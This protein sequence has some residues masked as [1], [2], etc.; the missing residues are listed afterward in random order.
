MVGEEW[1]DEMGIKQST[2]RGVSGKSEVE[3]FATLNLA[4]IEEMSKYTNFL[5]Q[6]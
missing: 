5:Y 2:F 4:K 1:A 3:C 6:R